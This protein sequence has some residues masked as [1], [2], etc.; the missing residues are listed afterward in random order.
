MEKG[1]FITFEGGEGSGKTTQIEKLST[2]LKTQNKEVVL[3]RE[4][5]GSEGGEEIRNLFVQGCA[6]RWEPMSEVLLLYAARYD[7]VEKLI[8]PALNRGAWVLCDRFFD[9]TFAY[10]GYGHNMSLDILEKLNDIAL[11][12]FK[13]DLTFLLDIDVKQGLKRAIKRE[14]DKEAKE[15]RFESLDISF[16]EKLRQGY[17]NIAKKNHNRIQII[18]AN[19]S[20]EDIFACIKQISQ[21]LLITDNYGK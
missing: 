8:K 16:H 5:G 11:D 4:P 2:W 18:D 3:T 19:N 14:G 12:D 10:Q 6:N 13:P 9:S 20:V 21:K 1:C 17:L 15:D 7:H